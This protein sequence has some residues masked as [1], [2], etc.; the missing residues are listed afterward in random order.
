MGVA[1][2]RKGLLV[3]VCVLVAVAMVCA[4]MAGTATLARGCAGS[5]MLRAACAAMCDP[6]KW[7]APS[8]GAP[9]APTAA[10]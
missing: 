3:A 8:A 4:A 6:Q 7:P 5:K 10:P 1:P 9:D 2:M